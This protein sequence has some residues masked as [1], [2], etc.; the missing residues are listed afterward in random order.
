MPSLSSLLNV[1]A[2]G[3]IVAVTALCAVS[4][5][6]HP[7]PVG[8]G[9]GIVYP[10]E[11]DLDGDSLSD[12][13]VLLPAGDPNDGNDCAIGEVRIVSGSTGQVITRFVASRC[14]D[15]FGSSVAIIHDLDGDGNDDLI[16]GAPLNGTGRAYVFLGPFGAGSGTQVIL[17]DDA[18]MVFAPPGGIDH[19]GDRVGAV[20]DLDG[21][22]VA[23]LRIRA[24]EGT[25]IRTFIVSGVDGSPLFRVDGSS[26]FSPWTRPQSDVDD[27]GDVDANDLAVANS[28]LGQ[29]GSSVGIFQGDVNG[30]HS[31]T[32]VD[33]SII[34]GHQGVNQFGSLT[35]GTKPW[36]G[37]GWGIWICPQ[38]IPPNFHCVLNC[39]GIQIYL[40]ANV[41][42]LCDHLLCPMDSWC[43]YA[44]S[45]LGPAPMAV[46]PGPPDGVEWES[47]V[48]V[49]V[50]PGS[51]GGPADW[52]VTEGAD[53]IEILEVTYDTFRFRALDFGSV[54]IQ[55]TYSPCPGWCYL[56]IP[57]DIVWVDS[58][59][60]GLPDHWE[61]LLGL[62]PHNPDTDGDGIPDG[63]EDADGDGLS[64]HDEFIH[65]TDPANPDSD[66]DGVSDG[67]EVAQA[68]D[69][70]DPSDGR[71]QRARSRRRR[72]CGVAGRRRQRQP[73]RAVDARRGGHPLQ[74]AR[75]RA[76]HAADDVPL[77]AGK[78]LPDQGGALGEQRVAAGLR[79]HG[80][81]DASGSRLRLGRRSAA[82]ARCPLVRRVR[83]R[84]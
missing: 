62:D 40:P 39:W 10:D 15:A 51:S 29:S 60:D 84:V 46:I 6:A 78:V 66:G 21:D 83:E 80:A 4:R 26:P 49:E 75:V 13:I 17:A 24:K 63:A 54:R 81:G 31:V 5:A 74:G 30:S 73:L 77:P 28:H 20:A 53:L 14:D 70:N 55:C 65:S 76:G 71:G 56:D 32:S 1:A 25:A 34:T 3:P 79:L 22:G 23:D 48:L 52:A 36:L 38:V 57:I 19:F 67:D 58:D 8:G 35:M 64:N 2:V 69:P 7:M 9:E 18:D 33:I 42:P 41:G 50:G 82:T 45:I 59:S 27:D 68:S 12:T 11:T 72:G 43:G 16:I 44:I 47:E 61:F 37:G